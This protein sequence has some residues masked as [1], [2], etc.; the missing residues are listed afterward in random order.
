M[1]FIKAVWSVTWLEKVV[2]KQTTSDW[3]D[4]KTISSTIDS[5]SHLSYGHK[6]IDSPTKFKQIHQQNMTF[7]IEL[8]LGTVSYWICF[9]I[10]FSPSFLTN[11]AEGQRLRSWPRGIV[12]FNFLTQWSAKD[13]NTHVVLSL[14][15]WVF[16]SLSNYSENMIPWFPSLN[17]V[18]NLFYL[19]YFFLYHNNL[20]T[21]SFQHN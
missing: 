15:N 7:S 20:F 14:V 16:L 21:L 8:Y 1:N 13:N 2:D 4:I 11:T 3:L 5:V 12:G 19:H 6:E 17:V 9:L 10:F 18:Y